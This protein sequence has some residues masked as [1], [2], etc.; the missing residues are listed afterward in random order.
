GSHAVETLSNSVMRI[1]EDTVQ[2]RNDRMF[3]DTWA[4]LRLRFTWAR[5]Q[6]PRVEKELRWLLKHPQYVTRLSERARPYLAHIARELER[7]RMPSELALLPA[8][9]SAFQPYARSPARAAGLWQ[10]I[11]GTAR[12][13]GLRH[14]EWYDGRL[15]VLESTRA[16]L[17][18]L[19]Q[20]NRQFKGNWLHAVASYNS[21]AGNV[22]AA[23]KRNRR[24]GK[25]TDFWSLDLPPETEAY[26]PKLIALARVVAG[27]QHYG[28]ELAEVPDEP[29]FS[30][31][32]LDGPTSLHRVANATGLSL[33]RILRLNPG[34]IKASTGPQGP[35]RIL[36]PD[37]QASQLSDAL[38]ENPKLLEERPRQHIVRRGESLST[39]AASYGTSVAALRKLNPDLTPKAD[40]SI[41]PGHSLDVP[42]GGNTGS[43]PAESLSHEVRQGLERARLAYQS[44][45]YQVQSGD[46]LWLIARRHGMTVD[47]LLQLNRLSKRHPLKPGQRL[48][49]RRVS[50]VSA[51]A[52]PATLTNTYVIRSGDSLWSIA[53]RHGLSIGALARLNGLRTDA[54]L[55]PGQQLKL[56][57][58]RSI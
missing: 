34:F 28:I 29:Y 14:D 50:S 57:P 8:V 23:I 43:A 40:S 45:R 12:A 55:R 7:R 1:D 38:Q 2:L 56:A 24:A 47:Q 20:L 3:V 52:A 49:V 53:R 51:K 21:G 19:Q 9:E 33:D 22:Q 17:D 18:Y 35:H 54:T 41:R 31:V 46:S 30:V 25:G 16:A 4:R 39:I 48:L 10:F 13:H 44:T 5:T 27:A 36:L 11:P 58:A 37:T 42:G 15:D 26:V 32:E 6:H